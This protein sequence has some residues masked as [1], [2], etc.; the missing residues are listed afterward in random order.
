MLSY[1][2]LSDSY[3]IFHLILSAFYATQGQERNHSSKPWPSADEKSNLTG[4]DLNSFFQLAVCQR[5]AEY[6]VVFD[7]QSST[8]FLRPMIFLITSLIVLAGATNR[9][10]KELQAELLKVL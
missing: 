7:S 1:G 6:N 2:P 3:P 10:K 8:F 9:F 4:P 5:R